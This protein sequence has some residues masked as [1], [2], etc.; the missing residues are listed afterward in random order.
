MGVLK[1]REDQAMAI[2]LLLTTLPHQHGVYLITILETAITPGPTAK[3]TLVDNSI[4]DPI[5]GIPRV[6]SGTHAI[7]LGNSILGSQG[8]YYFV[9]RMKRTFVVNENSISFAFALVLENG[10]NSHITGNTNPYYQVRLFNSNNQAIFSRDVMAN[11]SNPL[12]TNS[13]G[14]LFTNWLCENINTARFIGQTVTLEITLSDCGQG[15]HWG[16]GYFDDF[17][18]FNCTSPSFN[19]GI[20]LNPLPNGCPKFPLSVSGNITLPS[21]A[22]FTNVTL[23]V[24]DISNNVIATKIINSAPGGFFFTNLDYPDFYPSGPNSNIQ[25]NIRAILNYGISGIPQTPI[26]INNTNPPGPDV[27][28]KNCPTPCYEELIFQQHQAINSSVNYQASCCI[29][30]YSII[31]PNNTVNFKAGYI[32]SLQPGFYVSGYNTGLFHAYIGRCEENNFNSRIQQNS[33]GNKIESLESDVK[34]SPNPT[35]AY[36]NIYAGK[37]KVVSW[38]LYDRSGK[39]VLRGNSEQIDIQGLLK[40]SYILKI[41]LEKR[42]ISKAVIIK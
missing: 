4:N 18:G 9:T 7:R 25:F 20:T 23:Q 21:S 38:E 24:L 6:N 2:V 33:I 22:S 12:F 16:Y 15:G 36:I 10:G 35:S 13:N 28:F 29:T 27:S 30:S 26:I 8:D 11:P 41:N 1:P 39:S 40:G 17:C 34:I 42:H 37:E 31:N 14:I 32:I 19:P 3:A 5:V